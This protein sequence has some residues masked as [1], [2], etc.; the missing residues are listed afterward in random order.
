M[1]IIENVTNTLKEKEFEK[2]KLQ[3]KEKFQKLFNKKK[4]EVV[5]NNVKTVV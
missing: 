1:N 2:E 3:L 4:Q 5:T